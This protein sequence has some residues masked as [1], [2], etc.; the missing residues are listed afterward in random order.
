MSNKL[1]RPVK[2]KPGVF[3]ILTDKGWKMLNIAEVSEDD[4]YDT[5]YLT[6]SS[7]GSLPSG[8]TLEFFRD[9]QSKTILETNF[10]TPR[11]LDSGEV[12]Y[13]TKIGLSIEMACG[14]TVP[15]PEVFK[16]IAYH[17]RFEFYINRTLITQGPLYKYGIGFGLHGQTVENGQGVVSIGMPSPASIPNLSEIKYITNNYDLRAT[18]TFETLN[19]SMPT[20][21][22]G[23]YAFRIFL[24]GRVKRAQTLS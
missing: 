23:T 10:T 9:L 19:N 8:R 2:G 5:V 15:A 12:L 13:L 3:G 24:H 7:S 21:P 1:L 18:L 4:K 17:T 11:R 16:K 14:D 6:M 22:A 20:I